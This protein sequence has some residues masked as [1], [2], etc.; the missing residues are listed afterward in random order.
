VATSVATRYRV[1]AGDTLSEIAEK[2]GTTVKAIAR[3][4]HILNAN[5]IRIGQV[6]VIPR[7]GAVLPG[8]T[9]LRYV[10]RAGDTLGAIAARFGTTIRAIA[11][12]NHITNPNL[13]RVG[14]VLQ[15]VGSAVKPPALVSVPVPVKPHPAPHP[16]LVPPGK[17]GDLSKAQLLA[18]MPLAKR[19]AA[20]YLPHLNFAM[21]EAAI[22][23]PLR[24]AAFLAQLAHESLQL[25]FMEEIA[26]GAAYEGRI[27]LGNTH[28]GDGRRFKGRGPIQLTGRN[29]YRDAG[30]AL[31]I[32]LLANP[33]RAADPDVGFRVAGWFWTTR[34]LN[35]LADKRDFDRITRRINGGL[36]GKTDR[37]RYYA[38]ARRVL[39]A[40]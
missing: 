4:N 14:Q 40:G 34:G 10:V 21:R 19:V 28:P 36:N 37:D 20:A 8:P 31:G 16:S 25:K 12:A 1:R 27:D 33:K 5:L 15:I 9:P 29:N 3:A 26:S 2:F 23:T 38:V 32:D 7:P 13:I 22:T 35:A 6:L 17:A 11:R 30:H 24:R 39:R 18:I